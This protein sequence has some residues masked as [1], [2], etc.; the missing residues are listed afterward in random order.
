MYQPPHFREDDLGVQHALIRAHPLGL[1]ITCRRCGADRQ[2]AAFPSRRVAVGEGHAA[3]PHGQGQQP[4]ARDRGRRAGARRLPGRRRLHH[5]VLVRDQAGDR[6]GRADLELRDRA[7]ARTSAR[8]RRCR[9]AAQADRRPDRRSRG[10]PRRMPGRS[11][12][13]RTPTS[14][15]RSRA[16]SASRS[17]SSRSTASGRSARTARP[18]TLSRVAEAL[19][20]ASEPHANAEMADLV[21]RHGKEKR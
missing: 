1:L 13:R 21:R 6:Q 19:G 12:T 20:D 10:G 8:D 15:R 18:P 17:R 16:S 7:G 2:S 11:A 5:A 4:V 14:P 3:G 9:L